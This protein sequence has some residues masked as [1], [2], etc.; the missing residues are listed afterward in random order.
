MTMRLTEIVEQLMVN[1]PVAA[2][3]WRNKAGD[4]ISLDARGRLHLTPKAGNGESP[5]A[6][7]DR[8]PSSQLGRLRARSSELL[9]LIGQGEANHYPASIL[10]PW[11]DELAQV[12]AKIARLEGSAPTSGNASLEAD[13][14]ELVE[15][16]PNVLASVDE[17]TGRV[18]TVILP[19]PL[20][21]PTASMPT[22]AEKFEASRP[23]GPSK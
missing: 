20:S 5:S 2:Q 8:S 3:S 19:R 1:G 15:A 10:Q 7:A 17:T 4:L 16:N 14:R 6:D 21:A 22:P 13:L 11:R 9:V 23:Y 12:K 18:T